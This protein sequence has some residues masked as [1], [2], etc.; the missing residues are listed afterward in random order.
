MNP[1]EARAD[2]SRLLRQMH[3]GEI[4]Y[5]TAA[6]QAA[7]LLE[8]G[9]DLSI[10]TADI[11]AR[12]RQCQEDRR[13]AAGRQKDLMELHAFLQGVSHARQKGAWR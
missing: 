10:M 7:A 4:P 13:A 2:F 12:I 6:E 8:R 9:L 11:N 1:Y 3:M 5:G